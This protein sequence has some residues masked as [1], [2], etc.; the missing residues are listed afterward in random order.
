MVINIIFILVL[1]IFSFLLYLIA[2]SILRGI[3]GKK[4]NK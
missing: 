4:R 1:L 3:N 2:K